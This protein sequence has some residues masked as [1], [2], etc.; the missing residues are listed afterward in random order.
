MI[1]INLL[2]FRA[3]R[4]KE[5]VRRQISIFLLSIIMVIAALFYYNTMLAGEIKALGQEKM[6]LQNELRNLQKQS[7]EAKEIQRQLSILKQKTGVIKDLSV[8][9]DEAVTL[10]D[11]LTQ[12]VVPHRMWLTQFKTNGGHVQLSG[13]AVDNQTIADFMTRLEG[14]E[15]FSNVTLVSS[16]QQA[17]EGA[18]VLLKAFSLNFD[19][20]GL[21]AKDQKGKASK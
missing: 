8:N 9:R 17:F 14:V 10:M 5:N 6:N 21:S 2:P 18:K 16:R 1:R 13:V 15:R 7:R 3:A 11:T 19:K 20:Q 12:V 4:K